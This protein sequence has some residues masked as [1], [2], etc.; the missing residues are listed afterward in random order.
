MNQ[1]HRQFS[2][3]QQIY[4]TNKKNSDNQQNISFNNNYQFPPHTDYGKYQ[5]EQERIQQ[6][7]QY[8][9]EI[10][11]NKSVSKTTKLKKCLYCEN[12]FRRDRI[13][14]HILKVHGEEF[15][16]SVYK[17]LKHQK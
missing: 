13:A 6:L 15:M 8:Q 12:S 11:N 9:I 4:Q 17:C 14:R 2:R 5:L 10:N 16:G 1:N 3:R 7:G